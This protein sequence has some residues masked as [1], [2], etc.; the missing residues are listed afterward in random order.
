LE[1]KKKKIL[2]K[3]NTSEEIFQATKEFLYNINKKSFKKN[4][5]LQNFF[6]NTFKKKVAKKSTVCPHGV[7]NSKISEFFLRKI[8]KI[9]K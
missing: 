4:S 1:F 7:F 3:K 2:L 6:W 5:K 8:K 9:I